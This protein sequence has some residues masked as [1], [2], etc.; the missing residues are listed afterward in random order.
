[1]NDLTI[2]TE[3]QIVVA[4]DGFGAQENSG[5]SMIRGKMIKFKD[6]KF[7]VDKTE[8]LPASAKLIAISTI[9]AWVHWDDSKPVE[10]R[11]TQTGQSHPWRDELGDL[12]R[13]EWPAGLDGQPADPWRD[14]RYLHLIDPKTAAAYTFVTDSIGG[15]KAVGELKEQIGVYRRV[16]PGAVPIVQLV[17][18]TMKT[19]YGTKP[20]PEFKVVGWQHIEEA[21]P[22]LPSKPSRDMDDDIPFAPE[23]RG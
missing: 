19:K 3:H 14:T 17:S 22:A 6:G 8:T 18:T 16:N 12:D 9:M 11:V 21:K 7:T 23:F 1:M 2:T 13:E 4:D 5:A 20:R 10:H 15:K